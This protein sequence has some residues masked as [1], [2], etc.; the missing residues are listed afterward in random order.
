MFSSEEI[1]HSGGNISFVR[2]LCMKP[3]T[4]GA[5]LSQFSAIF[6]NHLIAPTHKILYHF[7]KKYLI[8]KKEPSKISRELNNEIYSTKVYLQKK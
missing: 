4:T 7:L 2:V 6:G 8:Y 3:Y 1:L 5:H